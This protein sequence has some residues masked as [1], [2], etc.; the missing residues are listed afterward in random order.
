MSNR[1]IV[2]LS[3]GMIASMLPL[4]GL[5]FLDLHEMAVPLRVTLI[6][7]GL[8]LSYAAQFFMHWPRTER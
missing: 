1:E 3:L 5:I 4:G 8:A 7:G 2:M 6:S